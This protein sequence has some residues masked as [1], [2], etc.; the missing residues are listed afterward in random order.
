MMNIARLT[1]TRTLKLIFFASIAASASACSLSTFDE[2]SCTDDSEC[3]AAFGDGAVCQT[4]GFCSGGGVAGECTVSQDCVNKNGFGS[5]CDQT[6]F[7]CRD[8]QETE[9]EERC[10]KTEPPD[11]LRDL[12]AHRDR[13]VFLTAHDTTASSGHLGRESAV[14]AAIREI[15]KATIFQDKNGVGRQFGLIMC[16]ELAHDPQNDDDYVGDEFGRSDAAVFV[17]RW[18]VETLGVAGII[19]PAGSSDTIRAFNEVVKEQDGRVV[20]MANGAASPAITTVDAVINPNP[21]DNSP[22]W[23]WRS[24]SSGEG[25]G[26][27]LAN[28]IFSR[29]E[30]NTLPITAQATRTVA[31]IHEK[32]AF[33]SGIADAFQ[34]EYLRLT[35]RDASDATPVRVSYTD[36][37]IEDMKAK[38]DIVLAMLPNIDAVFFGGQVRDHNE[39]VKHISRTGSPWLLRENLPIYFPQTAVGPNVFNNAENP[40]L[41]DQVIAA[42]PSVAVNSNAYAIF[43]TAFVET[44]PL[45]RDPDGISQ[46]AQSW[47]AGWLLAAGAMWAAINEDLVTGEGISRGIR[48]LTPLTIPVDPNDDAIEDV[49]FDTASWAIMSGVFSN[50][51]SSRVDARGATGELSYDLTTEEKPTEI[52]ILKSDATDG[53]SDFV[54]IAQCGEDLVCGPPN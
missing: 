5:I 35:Q 3:V 9:I 4:D 25:Q 21:N 31:L 45:G 6:D 43:R 42:N 47:D 50:S 26:V 27:V 15:N 11:L 29:D 1:P 24:S 16:D 36:G 18:G 49:Q 30:I 7:S 2:V 34:D 54:S 44:D 8:L 39:F 33:G 46:T 12:E 23:L 41:F 53:V 48:R 37:D 20:Q 28:D 38:T 19:G 17:A 32:G 13:I 52:T 14:R 10:D 40:N 22:G 51:D